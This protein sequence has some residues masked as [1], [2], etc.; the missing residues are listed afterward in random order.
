MVVGGGVMK[1][2]VDCLYDVYSG[3]TVRG[4]DLGALIYRVVAPLHK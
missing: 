2:S 4:D 1:S 3:D